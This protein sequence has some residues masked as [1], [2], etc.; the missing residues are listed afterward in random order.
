[1]FLALSPDLL[2]DKYQNIASHLSRRSFKCRGQG[3]RSRH[4]GS[5]PAGASWRLSMRKRATAALRTAPTR[6]R[7]QVFHRAQHPLPGVQDMPHHL[8]L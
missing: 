7:E 6:Q 5:L 8:A 1:M 3:S 2:H 4:V